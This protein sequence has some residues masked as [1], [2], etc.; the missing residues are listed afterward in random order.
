MQTGNVLSTLGVNNKGTYSRDGSFVV[1]L[2]D[3]SDEFGKVYSILDNNDKLDYMEDNSLL[4]VD[5][6]SILYLYD[7]FI[8]N[9]IADF[10]NNHYKVVVSANK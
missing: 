5:N 9:L 6:A 1:D 3:S 7:D 10:N 2:A 4:T 8:I